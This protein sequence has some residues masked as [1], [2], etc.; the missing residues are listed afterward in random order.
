M[1]DWSLS[2]LIATADSSDERE[3]VPAAISGV[4]MRPLLFDVTHG[5][6]INVVRMRTEGIV[7]RHHH[8]NPV[9]G[10]VIRGQW[11]YIER[12]WTA[13]AGTFIYEPAGDTHTLTALPGES[14]TLFT[15]NGAL[16]EVD[17][18][19]NTT[20]YA[21]VF[22]RIEQASQHFEAVGLGRDYVR[23]FIR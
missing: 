8:P 1:N 13:S 21:D 16:I 20:G 6:W 12:P 15:I 4:W 9:H 22:T 18:A 19:G 5:A 7:S 17:A 2:E 14:Q 11:R 3:W 23:Q 10:F